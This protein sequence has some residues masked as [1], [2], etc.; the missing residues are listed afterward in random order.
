MAGIRV[1]PS[2]S[3]EEFLA[4]LSEAAYRVALRHGFK[5]PF[6]EMELDL[7]QALHEV[8][9]MDMVISDLCGLNQVCY[10][11]MNYELWTPE[12]DKTFAEMTA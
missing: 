12:A 9:R 6:V 2:I 4:H 1:K 5:T 3:P 7:E 11:A 10:E 8:M